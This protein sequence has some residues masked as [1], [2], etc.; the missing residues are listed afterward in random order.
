MSFV[1][2]NAVPCARRGVA[3]L[4]LV[5]LA[6]AAPAWT[7]DAAAQQ[8]LVPG[9]NV[10]M[11]SGTKWPDGDPYLQR[12]NEPSVAASTRNPLHLLAGANDYRSV[13]I[14]F[15]AGAEETGDAW[16]GLFKSFDGGQ[17]WKTTLLPGY[18]QDTSAEGAASPIFGYQAGADPVVRAGTNGL[19]YY[20]GLVFDRAENGRS[21][22]FVAR[23]VDN[24]NQEDTYKAGRNDR[25]TGK[26]AVNYGHEVG[27]PIRYVGTSVVAANSGVAFLDKPWMAVDVPRRGSGTCQVPAGVDR[28]GQPAFQTV[29]AGTV[30]VAFSAIS[31]D[32]KGLKSDILLSRSTDCGTTWSTP[33]RVSSASDR[34]NQGA[35]IAIDPRDGTVYVAWRRFAATTGSGTD[36]FVVAR[37]VN[38]GRQFSA[39]GM[40]RAFTRGKGL[41]KG[42]DPTRYFE[43]RR[44]KFTGGS[45]P[46]A[47]LAEFDQATDVEAVMFRTNTYPTMAVDGTGR[48]YLAWTERGLASGPEADDARILISTSTNG[49]SWTAPVKAAEDG[50][51]GHQFMPS[52]V[53]GGGRLVLVYYDMRE[54]VSGQFTNFIDDRTAIG[55]ANK[56]HTMDLRASVATPGAAPAFQPSV[57]VSDYLMGVR[58][59]G[60]QLVEHQLQLNPPNLPMFKQ[61]TAPFMGDYV[62]VT[63]APAFVPT[64]GGGWRFNT[65]GPLPVFH[66]VWTDNRDVVKPTVDADGDGNPWNDYTPP[67]GLSSRT[68]SVFDPTQPLPNCNPFNVGSRNQNVYTARMSLGLVAG[69]PGNTKPL[70]PVLQRG[71]VVFAQNTSAAT[72]AFRLTIQNQPVGGRA[73]FAQFDVDRN[74]DG[75]VDPLTV[76][77]L[78]TP[79]SSTAARTVYATSTD[80]KAQIKVSVEEIPYNGGTVATPL[81]DIVVLNPDIANPDIANPDIA[82]PDIANPDIANPDI[83]NVEVYNPDIANPDIANP[84]IAN[85]DIANP[86]I[87]NPDIANP[88]IANPDIANPD[89]ANPDIANPDIANP[90]IANVEVANPDIANPD[91]ANPDIAN[92]DIANPD[93][94]NPDIA[95]PDIANSS[96]TD[97]TWT[98]VNNGNTTAAYN[99]NLF[100][101]QQ[102]QKLCAAGQDPNSTGCISTQLILR[103]LYTTPAAIGCELG[104]QSRNV[105]LANIENPQFV[106]PGQ[107]LPDQNDPS[108]TNATLWLAPGESAKITLR[109]YDPFKHDNIDVADGDP[110]TPTDPLNQVIDPIFLP[111]TQTTLGSVTPVVQQQAVDTQDK[112]GGATTPPIVT[113]LSPPIEDVVDPAPTALTVQFTQQPQSGVAPGTALTPTVQVRVFDQYNAPLEGAA[114][115]IY[116]ASNPTNAALAG[117][118]ATTVAGGYASFPGLSVDVAGTG[119]TLAAVSGTALPAVSAPFDVVA[120]CN[121]L[122]VTN[123]AD[124]GC[125]SLRE[126]ITTANTTAGVQTITFNLPG[127][128]PHVIQPATPLPD[129]T[130]AVIIDATTD[131]HYDGE[132]A[133]T[134]D[135]WA[136]GGGVGLHLVAGASTVKGL[137]IVRFAGSGG[138]G[139][140]VRTDADGSVI[141]QNHIG[142]DRSHA[143]ALG[144]LFGVY[145]LYPDSVTIRNNVLS[146]NTADGVLLVGGAGATVENN[147]IGTSHDGNTSVPNGNNGITMYDGTTGTVVRGNLISGNGAAGIDLQRSSTALAPVT[148]TQIVGNTIGLAADGT[149]LANGTGGVR[150]QEAA[151]VVVG[152]AASGN[153]I[154]GNDGPG[155]RVIGPSGSAPVIRGNRIGTDP[156]G[157]LA[158]RNR[159]EGVVLSGPAIVGGAGVGEGN[160]I[161][162]N[163]QAPSSGTGVLV[164]VG[165]AGS[166]ILGNVIGLSATGASLGNGYSG[167]TVSG[168]ASNVTIGGTSAGAR[169]VI[170]GNPSS[171]IAVYAV[172]STPPASTLPANITIAGNYIGTDVS[173]AGAAGNGAWGVSVHGTTITIGGSVAGAGNQIAHNAAGG[174]WVSPGASAVTILSNAFHENGG[175]GIDVAPAGVS[176]MAPV[177]SNV[178]SSQVDF[179]LP[180]ATSGT[181]DYELFSS[182]SCDPSGYGEGQTLVAA[183]TGGTGGTAMFSAPVGTWIT[184]TATDAAGTTEFSN[185]LQVPAGA[186]PATVSIG[187]LGAIYDGSVKAVTVT[188]NPLGLAYTVTYNGSATAPSAVG[189]YSVEAAV[190]Q[191]GYVGSA[192]ANHLIASTTQAGGYG[193]GPYERYCGSGVSAN[194]FGVSPPNDSLWS[195]QLLCSDGNHPAKFGN[196][197]TPPFDTPNT[198][199][200]CAPGEVMVGMRAIH[201]QVW[202]GGDYMI[203]MAPRCQPT[204]GGSITE[205]FAP[206]PGYPS[207]SSQNVVRDCPAGQA[208]TGVVGAAGSI[209]DSIA[210]VCAPISSAGTIVSVTPSTAGVAFAQAVTVLGTG[211]PAGGSTAGPF[212]REIEYQVVITQGG[213]D[214]PAVEVFL[215]SSSKWIFMLPQALTPGPATIR[216][217]NVAGTSV[218]NAV[219]VT[220]S[221][222]PSAPVIQHIFEA[223]SSVGFTT[224]PVTS[225]TPGA[226][227]TVEADGVS[228][229]AYLA[230]YVFT[231]QSGAANAKTATGWAANVGGASGGVRHTVQIPADL[232]VTGW[233]DVQV[234]LYGPGPLSNA[235]RFNAPGPLP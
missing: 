99:V 127:A 44:L 61:G 31:Q 92:P 109:V 176:G 25:V 167:V 139:I 137:G 217:R 198:Q 42:L 60:G 84:D 187:N 30:Y 29:P 144:N 62:D 45:S 104:V 128:L 63:I 216:L 3:T 213:V 108:L 102:T 150:L 21:A 157:T 20:A 105:L 152:S 15:V 72:K 94:A 215:A 234:Y 115:T 51:L 232:D 116:L 189:A 75:Q 200:A 181:Y 73:S 97:V 161:S 101:A 13:D 122:V 185:C 93:I 19:F 209:V 135:G 130:E 106:L 120:S 165:S 43:H 220:V 123:T 148:G 85:P 188:T 129:I 100:L 52:L 80:P 231:P 171:G 54:D 190:T 166:Q 214:Y 110:E 149:A 142:T 205:P 4:V 70:D 182:L 118:T 169:N 172:G 53:F 206:A 76:L 111:T 46:T 37:S 146:G 124:T 66:A 223:S 126:A 194:G 212:P 193:G 203:A 228:M 133:V 183:F 199:M 8:S 173:G 64:A 227:L 211:L 175:L 112:N 204:G 164:R 153:T 82:N 67:T 12:Q 48:V 91:I 14:P 145:S 159:F 197:D 39:P 68:N 11:V 235:V 56:R 69:S 59:F 121:P 125:G 22:V 24:N 26:Y 41:K 96:L 77:T 178:Q 38:Q 16:L 83:A 40:A 233:V 10:N 74:G 107:Q 114:V 195:A 71:F 210:L 90:D 5:T 192:T 95:N 28:S 18:P 23:F 221:G 17:R 147:Y 208:V 158:R 151:G 201:G 57:R 224:T 132:P 87:A 119:Y 103:K 36:G 230:T 81:S 168:G 89:I 218:T 141:E 179:T 35:T 55:A 131:P 78:A 226:W 47:E 134:I 225:L 49:H 117:A 9:R 184:M 143:A 163:G 2:G 174:V 113:P 34:I 138:Y 27:D 196:T 207:G 154:S 229:S 98:M 219:A 177:L 58:R 65:D 1:V 186:V 88:D 32:S 79:A 180:G 33:I 191:P 140:F 222:T 162:G 86:D 170:S 6:L 7:P 202:G 156:T 50:Q 136:Q 160:L 155:I